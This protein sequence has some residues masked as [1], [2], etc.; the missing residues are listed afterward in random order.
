LAWD[1]DRLMA[2]LKRELADRLSSEQNALVSE[3]N[4]RLLFEG[5]P[6]PMWLYDLDTLAF[7]EVNDAAVERYGYSR[8]EFL[9]MTIKEIRPPQEPPQFLGL[10]APPT[11]A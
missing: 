11:P 4:Y 9:A 5:H 7:L 6:Q 3:R 8:A 10:M 1:F 2:S